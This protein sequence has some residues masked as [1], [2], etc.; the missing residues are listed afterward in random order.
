MFK[1]FLTDTATYGLAT[2]LTRGIGLLLVPL[3][4][5]ILVPGQYGALDLLTVFGTLISLTIALEV[6][7]GLARHFVDAD[8]PRTRIEYASTALWFTLLVYSLFG[9]VALIAA[10]PL[11]VLVLGSDGYVTTFRLAVLSICAAGIFYLVQN[12]LRW[13]MRPRAY[14]TIS[15]VSTLVGVAVA[16]VLVTTHGAGINGVLIGQLTG[17]LLGAAGALVMARSSYRAVFSR[18]R[19]A[20][21]L[22]FSGPL[23]PSGIA[24]FV[25]LFIDRILIER[26]MSLTDVG[27]FGIGYRVA[28]LVTLPVLAVQ[29]AMTPLVYS[30]YREANTPHVLA[31]I[32]RY[33]VAL[34]LIAMVGLDLLTPKLLAIMA[35]P[36][37][38]GAA[39]VVPV[40]GPALLL[41][42]MYVFAPGLA[43]ERRTG[44]IAVINIVGAIVIVVLNVL[45]IPPFGILGSA[46]ADLIGAAGMFAAYVVLSQRLYPIPH[47]WPAM[48]LAV[49]GALAALVTGSVIRAGS[50]IDF[51]VTTVLV[52]LLLLWLIR[53]GL[54]EIGPIRRSLT[55]LRGTNG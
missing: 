3:Y 8:S 44:A 12:Q 41:A 35:P 14:G 33:F 22:R 40:L 30:R 47:E 17:N 9:A 7:Q 16:I 23:V 6:S 49:L 24:V 18:L 53:L 55:A 27:L 42:G 50:G 1:Q 2:I 36:A 4:T 11:S 45:L 13:E 43:I 52:V 38:S 39:V 25:A 37:Y 31:R 54:I 48:G 51:M 19:L 10:E 15:V 32:F 21:M 5:R 28:L 26:F 46:I 29:A 34:A 20:E